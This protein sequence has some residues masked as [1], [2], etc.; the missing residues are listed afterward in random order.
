M[1]SA[2]VS[3]ADQV[4]DSLLIDGKEQSDFPLWWLD[5]SKRNME[6][7]R[8]IISHL[9]EKTAGMLYASGGGYQGKPN[10]MEAQLIETLSRVE[11]QV[12]VLS[13]VVLAT[14]QIIEDEHERKKTRVTRAVAW[15][16]ATAHKWESAIAENLF[17]RTVAIA[18]TAAFASGIVWLLIKTLHSAR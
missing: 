16:K 1:M 12:S 15:V 6:G 2:T 9:Q 4:P 18:S 5:E 10:E 8:D 7:L 17:Y 13:N 11:G 14:L 3:R